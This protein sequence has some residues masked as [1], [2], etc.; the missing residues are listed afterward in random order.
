MKRAS[1][2]SRVRRSPLRPIRYRRFSQTWGCYPAVVAPPDDHPG[3]EATDRRGVAGRGRPDSGAV[4]DGG[5]VCEL[6]GPMPRQQQER[7]QAAH[8]EDAAGQPVAAAGGGASGLGGV[9]R[10]RDVPVG[11]LPEGVPASGAEAGSAGGWAHAPGDRL[12]GAEAAGALPGAG[13]GLLRPAG[14]RAAGQAAGPPAGAARPQGHPGGQ[15]Q[16]RRHRTSQVPANRSNFQSGPVA[17]EQ[18]GCPW[19]PVHQGPWPGR[20]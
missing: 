20:P 17:R 9:A 12:P 5:A 15:G 18:A 2:L 10:Q 19:W 14:A 7:R 3:R 1:P 16:H 6:G 11:P 8:R 13:G 4:P